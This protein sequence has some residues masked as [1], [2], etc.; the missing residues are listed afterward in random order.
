MNTTT[1]TLKDTTEVVAWIAANV[2]KTI[3]S[4]NLPGHDLNKVMAFM[5]SDYMLDRI[6]TAYTGEAAQGKHRPTIIKRLGSYLIARYYR[7]FGLDA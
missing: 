7:D 1:I 2:S 4:A 3:A 6:R 5:T